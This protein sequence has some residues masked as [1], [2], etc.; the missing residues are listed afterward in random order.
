[1]KKFVI[2]RKGVRK[3]ASTKIIAYDLLSPGQDY[4]DLYKAIKSYPKWIKLTESCY[5][6]ETVSSCE[7]IKDNLNQYMDSNDRIFV[8][9]LKRGSSW[10]N[11]IGD[12]EF[13]KEMSKE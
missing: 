9:P 13:F 3:L 1:M 5:A 6:I 8:G 11:I 12:S 7:S 10:R 4:S 2:G